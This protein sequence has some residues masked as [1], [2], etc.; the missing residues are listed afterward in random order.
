VLPFPTTYRIL[1]GSLAKNGSSWPCSVA[2][3]S[4][5][6]TASQ[7]ETGDR[8]GLGPDLMLQP[9]DALG[10]PLHTALARFAYH[11][12]GRDEL[13]TVSFVLVA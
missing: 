5:A 6:S 8:Q 11:A 10:L 7:S 1:A 4:A 13:N 12:T 3:R 2:S 9:P